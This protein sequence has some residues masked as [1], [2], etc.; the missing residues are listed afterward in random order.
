MAKM[1]R[2][3]L[4]QASEPNTKV[5][6]PCANR[7]GRCLV[8]FSGVSLH[9]ADKP[10]FVDLNLSIWSGER[11]VL[12]GPSGVGKSTLLRLLLET[13]HP[14]C[15]SIYFDGTE[16]THFPAK[17]EQNSNPYRNGI[18]VFRVNQ[19]VVGVRESRDCSTG[20]DEQT[21]RGD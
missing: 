4:D 10:I 5:I 17:D 12:L 20:T 11:L 18:S 1:H 3:C 19:L 2:E 7:K 21:R 13:L 9:F 8:E 16:I 15:G 6:E 14:W